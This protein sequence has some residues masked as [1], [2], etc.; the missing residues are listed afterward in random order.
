M[1]QVKLY[2]YTLENITFHC[3]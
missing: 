2:L 1:T 3:L